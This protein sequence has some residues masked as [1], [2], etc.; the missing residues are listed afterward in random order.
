MT[1]LTLSITSYDKD[2]HL[3]YNLLEEFSK[4]T[5]AP[6]EII[7]YSSGIDHIEN[8]PDNISIANSLVPIYTIINKKLTIQSI[9]RNICSK[10]AASDIIMFF[11]IDDIPHNQKIEITKYI[12][13]KYNPDFFLHNYTNKIDNQV[14]DKNN[15]EIKQ[16]IEINKNNTNLHCDG[17]PIHH[18]HI[19][20]KKSVFDKVRFNESLSYYRKEDGKFC[21]DLISNNYSGIYTPLKLVEYR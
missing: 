9:A 10:V 14:I 15:I 19:A 6:S 5:A 3:I 8:I 13:G 12:F 18:A 2:Y 4:Q 21:Q 11:D 17:W 16:N 7:F 1:D 20:V